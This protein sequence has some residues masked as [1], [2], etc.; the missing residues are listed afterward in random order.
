[1]KHFLLWNIYVLGLILKVSKTRLLINL[2]CLVHFIYVQ[3]ELF[4]SKI[5]SPI[6][7][8]L[9]R[10]YQTIQNYRPLNISIIIDRAKRAQFYVRRLFVCL[11][12]YLSV[13][14]TITDKRIDWCNDVLHE[15]F[16]LL[17]RTMYTCMCTFF[18]FKF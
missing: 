18:H 7:W 14:L 4:I 16:S 1:M 8:R 11:V 5:P 15:C 13:W 2:L 17:G 6:F 3:S 10:L 9:P 12:V